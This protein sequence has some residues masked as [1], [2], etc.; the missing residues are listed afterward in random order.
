MVHTANYRH[1]VPGVSVIKKLSLCK[2]AS[3]GRDFAIVVGIREG[4]YYRS[5]FNRKCMRIL[6]VHRK[7]SVL[8]RC[9]YGEV[10]L[11]RP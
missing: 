11:Y 1:L 10:R 8:E 6:S 4:P 5:Y 7:L 2:F 3:M 9:P